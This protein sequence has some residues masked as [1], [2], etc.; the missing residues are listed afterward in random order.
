MKIYDIL[1]LAGNKILNA[2]FQKGNTFPVTPTDGQYYLKELSANIHSLYQYNTP[3]TS[4]REVIAVATSSNAGIV[5]ATDWDKINTLSVSVADHLVF[6]GPL[7]GGPLAPTFRLL[8]PDDIPSLNT[9]KLTAGTLP[10]ARGGTGTATGSITGTGALT[11]TSA[12]N[13]NITL[14]PHGTGIVDVS[15]KRVIG[16]ATPTTGTDGANKDYVDAVA[17]GAGN[18]PFTAV[19]AIALSNITLSA[20]QT[21][22]GVSVI[23][24][25][26]VLVTAQSTGAQ[27]GIYVVA[28]GAWTRATD[29]NADAEFPAGKQVF[30]NEGSAYG[31]TV[32]AITNDTAITVGTTTI[33]FTQVGGLGQVTAGSG[34]T[35]TGNVLDVGAGTGITVAAD[36]VGLTGQ[37]LAL[38]NLGTNGMIARTSAGVVAARTIT[39]TAGRISITNGDGVSGNPTINIDT[40][41][42][43]QA[44]ITTLGTIGTGTWNGTLIS[45]TY[46]GTGV[47]NGVK[48]ITLGGNFTTSGAFTTT[49]TATANTVVTLPTTGT[50]ATLTGTETL[51]NKTLTSPLIAQIFGGSASG[52]D[53]AITST[54]HAT[55]GD[56][57]IG[58]DNAGLLSLYGATMNIKVGAAVSAGFLKV[59]AGTG[60]VTVDTATYLTTAVTNLTATAPLQRTSATGAT[61]ISI[62]DASTT[63]SGAVNVVAQAFMGIKSFKTHVAGSGMAMQGWNAD[64]GGSQRD[65]ILTLTEQNL[66]TDKLVKFRPQDATVAY[67]EDITGLKIQT[68]A[69]AATTG[70]I[71]LA[72]QALTA[73]DGVT[74]S[75]GDR[76]LVWQQTTAAQNGVYIAGTAGTWVRAWDAAT[77]ADITHKRVLVT[78]GTLYTRIVFYTEFVGTLGTTAQNWYAMLHVNSTSLTAVSSETA[79]AITHNLN[80]LNVNVILWEGTEQVYCRV[81]K[82]SATQVTITRNNNVSTLTAVITALT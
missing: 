57:T 46:G 40:S 8:D 56:I 64:G 54:S 81:T 6:A 51:T 63:L 35:K 69:V 55:K 13:G 3:T 68:T 44:T 67:I 10:V 66:T 79:T 71:N 1:E 78:G 48:T 7:S 9:S 77:T 37:A 80:S 38:H 60:A 22:D 59:A 32:W 82:T 27:N 5:T 24:G 18:A 33:S 58:S 43:G 75:A 17:Q 73:I 21:I 26:R 14:A 31:N 11:F 50:L 30:V 34:L 15:G 28:A 70:N 76:V 53:I 20:P 42:V 39:G 19:R 23:A 61:T 65:L 4:W 41:Y 72:T 62:T 36:T 2:S 29:A 74:P 47:N 16:M 45:P 49:F 12:S 25:D 52:A